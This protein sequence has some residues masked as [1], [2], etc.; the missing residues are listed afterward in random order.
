MFESAE[1]DHRV[2][3][4]VYKK[5]KPG[6][7]EALLNAQRELVQQKRFAVLILID[8]M[9]AAGKGETVQLL[10]TWMDP[11]YIHSRAFR[12]PTEEERERPPMWRDW[13]D[14]PA[15]GEIGI[16]FGAWSSVELKRL[17]EDG[18]AESIAES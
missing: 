12:A 13:R 5:E 2:A 8:S 14:L 6:V 17:Q 11:R 15:K 3:K 9:D 18:A 7:R 4:S 1:L 10:H 16:F